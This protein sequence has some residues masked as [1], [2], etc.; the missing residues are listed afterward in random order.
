MERG[1]NEK[2]SRGTSEASGERTESF[3][4]QTFGQSLE[5]F[6][7]A[8]GKNPLLS[9]EAEKDRADLIKVV[10]VRGFPMSRTDIQNI[11]FQYANTYKPYNGVEGLS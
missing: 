7:H 10:E 4:T 6:H 9:S 3:D 11:T 2:C 5:A 8:A 1:K